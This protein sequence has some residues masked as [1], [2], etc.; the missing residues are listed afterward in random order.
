MTSPTIAS[1]GGAYSFRV[2]PAPRAQAQSVREMRRADRLSQRLASLAAVASH[3][4][5][6]ATASQLRT[7]RQRISK[8]PR[9]PV[10]SAR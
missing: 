7:H 6:L 3:Q 1:L 9:L 5:D 4:G 8:S 10:F 2:T